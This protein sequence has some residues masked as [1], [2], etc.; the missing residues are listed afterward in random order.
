MS[1]IRGDVVLVDFP[2]SDLLSIKRR[3][4]L[5]VQDDRVYTGLP[6]LL[7]ALITSNISRT[8][9]TRVLVLK[10][11]PAGVAMGL[12]SDSV[13]VGDNLATVAAGAIRKKIGNCTHMDEVDRALRT[14]LR[15]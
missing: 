7:L 13:V 10:T 1:Y 4:A 9:P 14:I 12:L 11:S 3:P 8:G 6:Q 2:N 15:L 5:V